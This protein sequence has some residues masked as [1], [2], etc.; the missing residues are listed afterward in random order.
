V[1]ALRT[2]PTRRRASAALLAAPALALALA[3][4]GADAASTSS[5]ATTQSANSGG[6]GSQVTGDAD[7]DRDTYDLELAQC[8][9]D[10]GVDVKDPAPGE[11]IT[12]SGPEV[13]SAAAE[14]RGVIGDPPSHNWTPE[15][16]ARVHEEYLV[17]AACFRALGYDVE[18][19]APAEAIVVPEGL[20]EDEFL[21]CDSAE[22]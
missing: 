13:E 2:F 9:R 11:G 21:S 3:A 19:P 14:C 15:E 5:P 17:M 20:T 6:T 12:E 1:F 16:I 7:T 8:M 22:K 4:C 10:R 18:D